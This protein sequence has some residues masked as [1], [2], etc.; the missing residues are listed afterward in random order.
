MA[1]Y[2]VV[3][4]PG[5]IKDQLKSGLKTNDTGFTVTRTIDRGMSH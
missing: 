1:P 2:G 3:H 5:L 4:I